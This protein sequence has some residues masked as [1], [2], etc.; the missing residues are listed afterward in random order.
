MNKKLVL[1]ILVDGFRH[2]YINPVDSP[3][4]YSLGELNIEGKVRETFAFELRPAFFAGLQPDECQV[5][6]MFYYDP[7]GSPFRSIDTSDGDRG[8]ISSELRKEAERCGYSLVKH[9]GG[10]AEI[11]LQLLKYF[12]FS[13]KYHT[14]EPSAL[15]GH[16]TL[17]D[18]LKSDGRKWI[19]I[20]YP[21]GPGTTKE[22]MEIFR[23][24]ASEDTD[25]IFLHF[26][27]LDWAG[28]DCGPHSQKQK[29]VLKE[30]DE[31]IAEVY[32]I[33]N[34]KV[35]SLRGII[36]GDHGQVEIRKHIDIEKMLKE[37][38]LILEKDY[39]YFL[40]S[41]QARFW[42][43]NDKAR[44]TISEILSKISEGRILTESDYGRL[45]FSFPDNRFGELIFVM[46]EG[47]GIFPNFFQSTNPCKGLHGYLPEVEG[48]WAKIIVTGCGINKRIEKTIEMVD[49]FPT[50][51]YLLG[52]E[53]PTDVKS[54][55]VLKISGESPLPQK[56]RVSIVMPTYNRAEILKQSITA[57]ESQTYPVS[58]FELI[59]VDDGSNDGTNDFLLEY[60]NRTKLNFKHLRQENSGPAAARNRG[61]KSSEGNIVILIGDDMISKPD[62]IENH[63]KFHNE[64]P[65]LSHACL[66]MVEWPKDFDVDPLMDFITG[67]GGQQFGYE[68]AFSR[69]PDNLGFEFFWSS[70]IS[71]K[72]DFILTH[73]LFNSHVFKHA[74]WEDIELGFRLHSAGLIIHL[75]KECMEFHNHK[76]SF[77]EFSERQRMVGWYSHEV[78]KLG[79]PL[80]YSCDT[81]EKAKWYSREALTDIENSI[82]EYNKN[83]DAKKLPE[84]KMIYN[85]ALYYAA[86]VGYNERCNNVQEKTGGIVSLLYNLSLA[87]K[88]LTKN[89]EQLEQKDMQLEAK[90]REL[91]AVLNSYRWKITSPMGWLL[92]KLEKWKIIK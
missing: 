5:A 44:K 26:S 4:L 58:D 33:L 25:F 52:Y 39:I 85:T 36:F 13:E 17:F 21:D 77:R 54:Q 69:D 79:L 86:M 48:N 62:F 29:D 53:I 2:D 42:F 37:T 43:F 91:N 38:G 9:N 16:T 23:K 31:A 24:R 6:N 60:K 90:K 68:K 41:T 45:H 7:E 46:N 82:E 74:M 51:L 80:G 27:E 83:A 78:N 87:E 70:N 81:Y 3:F 66:G 40:D 89:T 34:Q 12:N 28:H 56:Y 71:F 32:R 10:C 73:G 18:Y 61:I 49:I 19:W 8:R 35:I 15:P 63:T 55:S 84:L 92:D 47:V 20:G 64:W 75:R 1:L 57:I 88:K 65:Q 50:L 76:V 72:R 22:V 14:A 30:I 59:V 11:P 67:E